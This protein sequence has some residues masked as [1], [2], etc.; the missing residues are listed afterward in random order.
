MA[1]LPEEI[2]DRATALLRNLEGADL[3]VSDTPRPGARERQR[4][5]PAAGVQLTL[6]EMKDDPLREELLGLDLDSMTPLEAM[7]TLAELRR[8]VL[9][10]SSP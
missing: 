5:N 3:S 9:E 1:G 10:S 6:F 2:T 7:R 4:R 8:R